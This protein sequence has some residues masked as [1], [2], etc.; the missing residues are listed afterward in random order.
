M[1]K[2][3]Q[4]LCLLYGSYKNQCALLG[5][6]VVELLVEDYLEDST[7]TPEADEEE[8]NGYSL[9]FSELVAIV[10][11]GVQ[12]VCGLVEMINNL[13]QSSR[14]RQKEEQAEAEKAKAMEE[15]EKVKVAEEREKLK[16]AAFNA[17][18]ENGVPRETA[19]E[20]C[21]HFLETDEA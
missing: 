3:E 10:F 4:V 17:L 2:K 15:A 18:L 20:Y 1:D 5:K 14:E 8:E 9:N 16:N 12:T 13:V 19:E 11:A 6:D 21:R 7:Y